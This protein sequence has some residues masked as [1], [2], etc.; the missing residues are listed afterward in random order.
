MKKNGLLLV[1]SFLFSISC[2]DLIIENNEINKNLNDFES[3]WKTAKQVYPFFQFKNIDW[4]SLYR[5]YKP[6]AL[7][8]KGD[9]I[10]NVLFDLFCELKDGHIEIHTEGGFPVPTYLWPRDIDRKSFS[11][12]VVSNYIGKQLK[13]TGK[14]N[15]S[16]EIFDNIGYIYLSTFEEGSWINNFDNILDYMKNTNGLILDVRNN[17]GGSGTTS[18]FVISRF[19]KQPMQ[20][21]MIYADGHIKQW[22][23]QPGGSFTYTNQVVILV[24]G[25]SFSA[26][27]LLPELMR[28]LSNVTIVGSTTGGGGGSNDIYTLPSG[29]RIKMPNS[30][31]TRLDGKLIEW[32]GIVPDIIVE[33]TEADKINGRDKQLEIARLTLIQK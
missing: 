12:I 2:S 27:E 5:K 4:D 10:Y 25:S 3:A 15:I 13:L 31:F 6:F 17:G 14:N 29:K 26:A 21:K 9:E 28:Q 20:E 8:S 22:L 16:Y 23:I 30:Y 32:N 7:A 18:D 33:Q 24:N 1:L 19:I 11:Q